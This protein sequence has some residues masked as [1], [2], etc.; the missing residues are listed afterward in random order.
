MPGSARQVSQ[1]Q[2]I[3]EF[4]TRT[5]PCD[6]GHGGIDPDPCTA[7]P[8]EELG[9][10]H[11]AEL[12]ARRVVP[13]DLPAHLERAARR[14]GAV[15]APFASYD[16]PFPDDALTTVTT[17]PSSTASRSWRS[18]SISTTLPDPLRGC[19]VTPSSSAAWVA[20]PTTPSRE[21][22]RLLQGPHGLLGAAAEVA[23]G[24]A[25]E[26]A[27]VGQ[28]LL[29]RDDTLAGRPARQL[30]RLRRCLGRRLRRGLGGGRRR[31]G[32]GRLGG[33]RLGLGRLG[34]VGS[35]VVVGADGLGLVGSGDAGLSEADGVRPGSMSGRPAWQPARASAAASAGT[36]ARAT[37]R[38][39]GPRRRAAAAGRVPGA[40]ATGVAAAVATAVERTVRCS[41]WSPF[42]W[43]GVA[44][45]SIMRRAPRPDGRRYRFAVDRD[46]V[47]THGP[48]RRSAGAR[49]VRCGPVRPGLAEQRPAQDVDDRVVGQPGLAA[50][51]HE[52]VRGV[53]RGDVRG[54]TPSATT[55]PARRRVV[56]TPPP[57]APG[58]RGPPS[59]G[60]PEV[61][62]ERAD[63]REAVA[64]AQAPGGD[65]RDDPAPDLLVGARPV[66]RSI[67][68]RSS[69]IATPVPR[70]RRGGGLRV[71]V[72]AGRTPTAIATRAIA[73]ATAT[74]TAAPG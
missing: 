9:A 4:A 8:G 50:G 57:R 56:T 14:A 19:G 27:E 44:A 32:L 11:V 16:S 34:G 20:G 33:R 13:V 3:A 68:T 52:L 72:G 55:V 6:A 36:T 64:D 28:A 71:G 30:D 49:S 38:R 65:V 29:E 73:T 61:G 10:P 2:F 51:A 5:H 26:V 43:R 67:S 42:V 40:V 47:V 63:R 70:G 45:E 58:T 15:G 23:V 22:R 35:G 69:P 7:I 59:R 24:C 62:R 66:R 37:T 25:D 21:A 74:S 18:R 60:E 46:P 48:R 54:E 1:S 41:T 39:T 17:R 31:A 12:E 53:A